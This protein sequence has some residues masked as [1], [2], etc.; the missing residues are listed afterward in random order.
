MA[1]WRWLYG[2]PA[3]IGMECCS[4]LIVTG[5]CISSVLLPSSMDCLLVLLCQFGFTVHWLFMAGSCSS[6]LGASFWAWLLWVMFWNGM[7]FSSIARDLFSLHL[8]VWLPSTNCWLCSLEWQ[9]CWIASSCHCLQSWAP[10]E[11]LSW[12]GCS[13]RMVSHLRCYFLWLFFVFLLYIWILGY[14]TL[15]NNSIN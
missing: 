15:R 10:E 8:C 13:P 11:D 12:H 5:S 3:L 4:L 1:V 9:H 14:K 2:F 6:L 7:P